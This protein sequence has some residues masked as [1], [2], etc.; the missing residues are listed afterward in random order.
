MTGKT[1]PR[2][3]ARTSRDSPLKAA[4][5]GT[6]SSLYIHGTVQVALKLRTFL[7]KV[8]Q[9]PDTCVV[10][11]RGPSLEV[12]LRGQCCW[13]VAIFDCSYPDNT[14]PP[15]FWGS[16]NSTHMQKSSKASCNFSGERN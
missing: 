3:T 2:G 5:D 8:V 9:D 1:I 11:L 12:S 7:G 4:S 15:K 10:L 14:S 13:T 16:F 6:A